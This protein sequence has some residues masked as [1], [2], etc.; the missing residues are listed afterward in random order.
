MVL[1]H[2]LPHHSLYYILDHILYYRPAVN[3]ERVCRVGADALE[4]DRPCVDDRL[5]SKCVVKYVV[6]YVVK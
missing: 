6:K 1:L 2:A 4:V 5:H 3:G